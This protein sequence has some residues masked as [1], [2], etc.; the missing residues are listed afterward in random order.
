MCLCGQ[1]KEMMKGIKV[2][3]FPRVL[4]MCLLIFLHT[5]AEEYIYYVLKVGCF[6]SCNFLWET[7]YLLWQV[8]I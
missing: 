2:T 4:R 1:R 5:R 3:E 8:G 6:F 7:E